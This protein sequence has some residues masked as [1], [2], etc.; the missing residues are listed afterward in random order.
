MS[1][2]NFNQI[3]STIPVIETFIVTANQ[4]VFT[5]TS[6][7]Y[8]INKSA[9]VFVGGSLGFAPANGSVVEVYKI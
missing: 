8:D 3:V 4:T 2:S 7:T 5:L 9:I 1:I 6:G